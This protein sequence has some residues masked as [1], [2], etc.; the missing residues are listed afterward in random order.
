MGFQSRSQAKQDLFVHTLL[1]TQTGRFFD[2][3]SHDPVHIS[4]TYALEQIGWSGYLFDIEPSWAGPTRAKRTSPF[5]C[6][7]VSTFNWDAFLEK[8]GLV[9]STI[10]YLSFD[11]DEAS[12][13][14]LER[15]PFEKL[16]FGVCT[17]EHDSYRFG[18]AR[19]ARM[20]QILG[21][22][23][24]EIVCKD[25]RS[26]GFAYEDWYVHPSVQIDVT[27]LQCE[28][29]EWTEIVKKLQTYS[30]ARS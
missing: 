10:D 21:S 18:A 5:I 25:V 24:Y 6:A 27:G 15:F 7:D 20:R 19:A 11:V 17:I 1:P 16:T 23:G 9:G 22:H 8:E 4:N 30:Q 26:D 28:G 14:T 13:A 2:I 12:L 29:L 3:G